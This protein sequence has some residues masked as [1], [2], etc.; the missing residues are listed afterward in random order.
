MNPAEFALRKKTVMVVLTV[1]TIIAGIVT[2][3]ELGRLEDPTFTIKTALVVTPYPGAS[4]VQVEEEVTNVVER[5]IQSLGQV[6]EIYST[7]QEGLS[8]VY[9]DIKSTFNSRELPQ[10]W[11]EMRK[12]L[13]DKA[14]SLP[15]GAGPCQVADD[16]GDVYGLFFALSSE[17]LSYAELKDIA[18][19][20]RT[21]LLLCDDVA[22]IDYWG[23]QQEMIYVEMDRYR[24]N[25][26]GV[27]IG[28]I[29][30]T[31]QNQ[32]IV[33]SSGNVTMD[34]KYIRITP[35]AELSSVQEIKDLLITGPKGPVRIGDIAKV[36]RDYM[37]P[38]R[39][40]MRF[41]G[42]KAIGMGISTIDGGNVITMGTS[43]K[44]RLGE[45]EKE[46]DA[47]VEVIPVYYQS[48]IVSRS[49]N[50]FMVN[51]AQSITIVIVLL[52]LFMGWQS[53][54][55]IGGILLLN[56]LATF[57]GM[58]LMDIDLQKISLG[59]LILALGMLVDN[60]IVVAEGILIRVEKG[61]LREEAAIEVV[62]DTRWPLLGATFVSIL[63]F[64]AIGY[65][66]GNV[67][68]FCRSLFF[69]MTISLLISWVLAVT[70]T[71][72]FCVWFL[73]IP[74]HKEMDDPYDKPMFRVYR[75][76]LHNTIRFRWISV[77]LVFSVLLVSFYGFKHVKQSF[78]PN[79]QQKY[80]YFNYWR[81][82]GTD[83]HD[84]SK[85]LKEI[86]EYVMSLDGVSNVS[87]FVG[88]GCLRF[89]LSYNYEPMNSAYGQLLVQVNDYEKIDELRAQVEEHCRLKY[90]V[91]NYY[92]ERVPIGPGNAYKISYRFRGPDPDVLRD[93]ADQ[94][95]VIMH[96]HSELVRDVHTNWR[97]YIPV[98]EP[99]YSEDQARR[100][101]VS[102][103]DI[104]QSLQYNFN[105]VIT[106][107]YREND[108]LI[109]IV[110]RAEKEY[111][112]EYKDM[113]N[114]PV[115]SSVIQKYVPLSQVTSEVRT[116]WEPSRIRHHDQQKS[117]EVLCN[118]VGPLA[119]PVRQ[120]LKPEIEGIELPEGYQGVWA[121]EYESSEEGQEPL[122]K[123]F[124]LCMMGMFV[125]IIWL[126]NSIRRPIIIF[127]TVP[128][129]VI[130]VAAGL[131]LTGL[132]FG[133]MAILG[134]LGLSGMILKNG[135]VLID[136]VELFLAE[137][138]KP[139][140]AVLDASVSRMRPV[141]MAAG[142]TILGMIP[143]I[144]DP[145]YSSMAVTIMGGLFIATFL[146]LIVVPIFYCIAYS[147][148][149]DTTTK[150]KGVDK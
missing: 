86:E 146:T 25:E 2:Y 110:F 27:P 33:T 59:A 23:L 114:L 95:I 126:F 138:R 132:P 90:P 87:T 93:L 148:K 83:I 144:T 102:R 42:K 9:V 54:L 24:M 111:R 106:G 70:I 15:P 135:I 137:G 8:I 131:L 17:E 133:F 74:K 44:K 134:F 99:V 5:T 112:D 71:P 11:D 117:I 26:L 77:L 88:E 85:D 101:G 129:A 115:W 57:I 147:I 79:S 91:A 7:S 69:V 67:G 18:T 97:E 6:D 103:N 104:A 41:N 65:A 130:G 37:D 105:G 66:P 45:L 22:K 98:I 120:T 136:Q 89:I 1:L 68:E 32:N 72:L 124:P 19:D 141:F 55:L 21:E 127:A 140:Q 28:Q 82:Q 12:K 3:M 84:T 94:A 123:T 63:A 53:G 58:Y 121:A 61:E 48:E 113:E 80:F 29:V 125:I 118:P 107:V 81:A 139:Y 36:S 64:A 149:H 62:R 52:M 16:F 100:V 56:I 46:L 31:I 39:N 143:L 47:Q 4:A 108:E 43:I 142:T 30:Q 49:V 109:P 60:A 14:G 40:I 122:R 150:S 76:I 35:T 92:C 34:S 51:L 116:K 50:A 78:F 128:L 73:H 119:E 38:P 10:I 20:M 145:L 13:N 75:K 96:N